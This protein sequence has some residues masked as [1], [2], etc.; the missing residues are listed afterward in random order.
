VQRLSLQYGARE[1]VVAEVSRFI[2]NADFHVRL[3]VFQLYR[4]CQT[5]RPGANH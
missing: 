2:Y 4:G 3:D 1:I 5:R